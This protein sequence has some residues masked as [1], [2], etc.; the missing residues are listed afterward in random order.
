VIDQFF[1]VLLRSAASGSRTSALA[2]LHWLLGLVL[3]AFIAS[4]TFNA[5]T[6]ARVLF[7]TL[8]TAIVV[9]DAAAYVYLL[10]NDRDAL[11]SERFTIEKMRIEHGLIGDSLIGV[12]NVSQGQPNPAL[13]SPGIASIEP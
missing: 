3:A 7:A 12:A 13:P 6:W 8:S 5:P 4:L 1:A 2:P 9:L 10:L 11:R